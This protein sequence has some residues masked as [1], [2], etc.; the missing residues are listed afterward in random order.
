M[1]CLPTNLPTIK[2]LDTEAMRYYWKFDL[3]QHK[4]SS[5]PIRRT[6][7]SL[8]T[9]GVKLNLES[10]FDNSIFLITCHISILSMRVWPRYSSS[11]TLYA[12]NFNT[13]MEIS[14]GSYVWHSLRNQMC[15]IVTMCLF[16]N[17]TD[18]VLTRS[19]CS[20]HTCIIIGIQYKLSLVAAYYIFGTNSNNLNIHTMSI[21]QLQVSYPTMTNMIYW[22][23]SIDHLVLLSIILDFPLGPNLPRLPS[24]FLFLIPWCN[25]AILLLWICLN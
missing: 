5:W 17:S 11:S 13:L 14:W 16:A 24:M 7:L 1:Q 2:I 18:P 22:H 10:C 20:P 19:L 12:N 8:K 25:T 21:S 23:I 4:L 6:Y 9:D 3:F 15:S